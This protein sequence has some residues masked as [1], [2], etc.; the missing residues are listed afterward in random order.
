MSSLASADNQDQE[1]LPVA[2]ARF[3]ADAR[4]PHVEGRCSRHSSR[5]FKP[6]MHRCFSIGTV[7]QGEISY[8]VEQQQYRIADIGMRMLEPRELYRAQGFPASYQIAPAINGKPLPKRAQVRMCGN[9]VS[10]PL[11]AALARANVPEL[12]TLL[13]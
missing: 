12:M 9:S 3:F 10:P 13:Q 11:A 8:Q 7:E 4:L 5:S 1:H 6:H 2:A